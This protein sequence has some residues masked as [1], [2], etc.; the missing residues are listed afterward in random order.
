MAN[1]KISSLTALTGAGVD[2]TADVLPIVDTSATTTKKILV[3]ELGIALNATQAGQ[4]AGTSTKTLVSPAVQ[5]YHPSAAKAWCQVTQSAGTYTLQAGSYNVTSINKTATG[6]ITVTFT[7]AFSATTKMAPIPA[8]IVAGNFIIMATPASTSTVT[9]T[10]RNSTDGTAL[11]N[12]F[13]LVV[14]GD[15]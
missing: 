15:Q 1:A 9:I 6:Q 11:D 13:S 12:D 10:I 14:F 8:N 4:E 7:T 3:E 5:Q 2:A